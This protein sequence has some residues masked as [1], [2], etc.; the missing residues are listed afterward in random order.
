MFDAI[1]GRYDVVNDALSLGLDRRWRSLTAR[2]VGAQPG[3]VVLDLGAGTG[4][5]SAQLEERVHVVGLDLSAPMLAVARE[6]RSTLSA[7]QGSAFRLPFR[8]RSFDAAVSA[9]VLRNLADLQPAFA[10]LARVVRPGGRVALLD[11]TQPRSAVMR[12]LFNG[13]FGA[14]APL[15]GTLVG[16]ADAYRYLVRSVSTL[17]PAEEVCRLLGLVGFVS[18]RWRLMGGGITTLWTAVRR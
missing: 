9:F 2:A 16:R 6:R 7:V 12:V 10:E 8:A 5:L 14:A 13:Y 4:K 18:C 11:I 3:D 15:L 1:V 17:P